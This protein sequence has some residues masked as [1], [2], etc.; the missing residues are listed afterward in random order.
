MKLH[1]PSVLRKALLLALAAVSAKVGIQ[2]AAASLVFDGVGIQTYADFGQNCGRYVAGEV[3][4]MLQAIRE[5]EK[6][7]VIRYVG[8]AWK[9][10][11]YTISLDQGMIDFSS[12]STNPV[13]TAVGYGFLATVAH[14]GVLSPTY[15]GLE[16]GDKNAIRYTSIDFRRGS[17]FHLESNTDYK[18]ARL[19]KLVTD[20]QPS[21][22]YSGENP[23]ELNGKYLYR[24]GS[25]AVDL[26]LVDANGNWSGTQSMDL[27]YSF[28]SGGIVTIEWADSPTHKGDHDG[29]F[30]IFHH[31]KNNIYTEI[32][33]KDFR[34]GELIATPNPLPYRVRSGDS[35]S[36]TW[37]YNEEARAYQYI[38]SG[39][40][41]GTYFSQD[42]GDL[43]WSEYTLTQFNVTADLGT[44]SHTI[45]IDPVTKKGEIIEGV[46]DGVLVSTT[47]YRGSMVYTNAAGATVTADF[48][49]VHLDTH[50]WKDL[51]PVKELSNWF[52]Y[53]SEYFNAAPYGSTETAPNKELCYADLF[54]T[55]SLV[56]EA[57]DSQQYDIQL[58]GNVDLGVGF[59]QFSK[60]ED[61]DSA[62][63]KLQSSYILDSAGF[64]IDKDVTLELDM[65][66]P[67]DH[68]TEWRK[69]GAGN[70]TITGTGDTNALLNVG[71]S[72][73]VSL[74]RTGG[75]AA[76]NVLVSSGSTLVVKDLKQVYRDVTLGAGGATLDLNGNDFT[77]NNSAA[78][79][80]VSFKSL[81]LLVEKDV[82]TNT[83]SQDITI[84]IIDPGTEAFVGA[85]K[86]TKDGGAIHVEYEGSTDREWVM[87]TVF[88]DLSHNSASD[89]TVKQGSVVLQGINTVHGR[90]MLGK[91]I[92]NYFDWH[93]ADAK[94]D[95]VVEDGAVF[96]LGSHA[97]LKGNVTVKNGGVFI[98]TEYTTHREEYMEGGVKMDDTYDYREYFGLHGDI[99]LV[100]GDS[101]FYVQFSPQHHYQDTDSENLYTNRI[102]GS[103]GMVVDT[104]G[105]SLRLTNTE[106][107]FRGVKILEGGTLA[108]TSKEALGDTSQYQW[109][110]Q[111]RGILI[112]ENAGISE[113]LPMVDATST[114]VLAL[115]TDVEDT[116]DLSGHQQ[117]IIGAVGKIQ[118]GKA[119]TET[120]LSANE[121]H[122]W[123]LGGGGGELYVNYKLNDADGVLVLGNQYTTG[124]VFLT[125]K[126]N[127]LRLITLVG[128]VTLDYTDPEALGHAQLSLKYGNRILGTKELVQQLTRDSDG[129]VLLDK[130]AKDAELD[131]RGHK[132]LSLSAEGRKVFSGTIALDAD[133]DTYNLGGGGGHLT[134]DTVLTDGP[135]NAKR[136]VLVDGQFFQAMYSEDGQDGGVIELTKALQ[137][138][139]DVT[140]QGFDANRVPVDNPLYVFNHFSTVTLQLSAEN[141][142]ESA[143]SILLKDGGFIDINGTS[144]TL[145]SLLCDVED[146]YWGLYGIVDNSEK[147][148]GGLVLN[149]TAARE[150]DSWNPILCNLL[151][152]RLTKTGDGMLYM[153]NVTETPL[154]SIED[155]TVV[156]LQN[157]ALD[158]RGVT[159][160]TGTGV[161][162][163]SELGEALKDKNIVLS[164][165][166][167]LR[168]GSDDV[169]CTVF[170]DNGQ[171]SIKQADGVSLSSLSGGIGA[172]RDA[173]L[174][175]NGMKFTLGG[176]MHNASGGTIDLQAGRLLLAEA[177]GVSIG[178]TLNVSQDATLASAGAADATYTIDRLNVGGR[179]LTIENNRQSAFWNIKALD[180]TGAVVMKS[181]ASESTL[182]LNGAGAFKGEL[183]VQGG[184]D[185]APGLI[186]AHDTAAQYASINLQGKAS[187]QLAT[188]NTQI[189]GLSG[190]AAAKVYT[191]VADATLTTTGEQAYTFAGSIVETEGG[192][193]NLVHGGS[194]HQ[195]YSGSLAVHNIAV[196]NGVLT[197]NAPSLDFTGNVIVARGG[198]LSTTNGNL[199]LHDGS[200]LC[201]E[202]AEG[203]A[204]V[205]TDLVVFNGGG[206]SFDVAG[207]A[208]SSS[209][210]LDFLGGV[211]VANGKTVS[212]KFTN[213]SALTIGTSLTLANGYNSA[214]DSLV[215]EGV[216]Y[217]KADFSVTDD[218]LSVAFSQADGYFIWDGTHE[219]H[220]WSSTRFG[221]QNRSPQASEVAVFNDSAVSKS[222]VLDG[223]T[224]V[225]SVLFDNSSDYTVVTE[226][227]S[228]ASENVEVRG[229]GTVTLGSLV[230][231]THQVSVAS[232]ATLVLSDANS[233]AFSASVDGGGKLAFDTHDTVTLDGKQVKISGI[234]V[235]SGTLASTQT[236]QT[237]GL[238][239]CADA[240]LS[241]NQ[242]TILSWGGTVHSSGT[243]RIGVSGNT[244]LTTNITAAE[245]GTA[246]MLVKTG[247]GTL[248]VKSAVAA[249]TVQVDA[250]RLV[251]EKAYLPQFLP[252][253]G[254]VVVNAGASAQIGQNAQ[255]TELTE[256]GANFVVNGGTLQ[257]ALA[258]KGIKTVSGDLSVTNGGTLHKWDGGLCFTGKA[259][260]G[261][262]AEDQVT[263]L[264]SWGKDGTIF[265]GLVE[266][267]GHVKLLRGNN[268]MEQFAFNNGAN[269]F[270]GGIE[271]TQGTKLVAGHQTA[272]A[273]ASSINLANNSTLALAADAV[274]IKSLN[275]SGSI[276]FIATE[277]RTAAILNITDGGDFS[278]SIEERI[279]INK[280]GAGTLSLTGTSTQFSGELHIQE[281]T[282]SLGSSAMDILNGATSVSVGRGATLQL[283]AYASV[284]G[285][286]E[287]QGTL[288]MGGTI[289]TRDSVNLGEDFSII[290]GGNYQTEGVDTRVYTVFS[291]GN[292]AALGEWETLDL[293]HFSGIGSAERG[294]SIEKL[295]VQDNNYQ[296]VVS[297]K[298][299]QN[300]AITWAE[301]V[302][303]GEWDISKSSNFT[304]DA[305]G[306]RTIY[307]TGDIVSIAS[308][309]DIT[310]ASAVNLDGSTLGVKAGADATIRQTAEHTLTM[311]TLEVQGGARL[312]INALTSQFASAANVAEDGLLEI[313]VSSIGNS[314]SVATLAGAGVVALSNTASL[315]FG[316]NALSGGNIDA[317]RFTGTLQLG[318]G[319]DTMRFRST[320]VV[321]L[322]SENTIEL[323]DK[324]QFWM[325]NR[326]TTIA[327][328]LILHGNSGQSA[329]ASWGSEGFGA[330]RGATA[331]NGS[332]AIDG[333]AMV[334]GAGSIAFNG[335][336][337][338]M[339]DND[340]LTFGGYHASISSQTYTLVA[341]MKT[342]N[343]ANMVVRQSGNNN[344]T[345]NVESTEGL[346][347]NLK[348]AAGVA[349]KG[350]VNVKADNEILHMES[351]AGDGV[352]NIEQSKFLGLA[353]GA[354]YG[355]LLNLAGAATLAA[356]ESTSTLKVIGGVKFSS[357]GENQVSITGDGSTMLENA[358]IHLAEGT[359]LEMA[360]IVLSADSLITDDAATIVAKGMKMAA[361]VGSNLQHAGTD[362]LLTGMQMLTYGAPTL[363]KTVES[364]E[365]DVVQFT[366]T[367]IQDVRIEG[368]GL[369]ISL[370]GDSYHSFADY[371]WASISL[372]QANGG[373]MFS[374]DLPVS[375]A[376]MAADGQVYTVAGMYNSEE[377]LQAQAVGMH[378]TVYFH[379]ADARVP[380]PASGALSLLALAAL[381]TRRRRK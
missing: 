273:K 370:V 52:N 116:V 343:L 312:R 250:G 164:G 81:H 338:G 128:G 143:E 100:D 331:F 17:P 9:N 101:M 234:E 139:G 341:G 171:A 218:V 168:V 145:N 151:V 224:Q 281:G 190:D 150:S 320:R 308:K 137:L 230:S 361:N 298:N 307:M 221:Q 216:D 368:T 200:V 114:G 316:N 104:A 280:T 305:G 99:H 113:I 228:L 275:G 25:G 107:D 175:L 124:K 10:E 238:T 227:G 123:H 259:T 210:A 198:K 47:P 266:G 76:Y 257:L 335:D 333:N 152:P 263:L 174:E 125:N 73:T 302:E 379:M 251:V 324:A 144:Q 117:L 82:V 30:G 311:E 156:I 91:R 271:T 226:A 147:Q 237:S 247:G 291:G 36:P 304:E 37:V 48:I 172:A 94:M 337:K 188:G 2:S 70:L 40:S 158:S 355:G 102:C 204:G 93:Y 325:D 364:N 290:L 193:M 356:Q 21:E 203:A 68:M 241:T 201:S 258:Q 292:R 34:T 358:H 261:A 131:L 208:S 13:D 42:R 240:C 246:G 274:D 334:S 163:V 98:M 112:V 23:S 26:A 262:S 149:V 359:R 67:K 20:V 293:S 194:G 127:N 196:Q 297:T 89:F 165:G 285:P 215:A 220:S 64:A 130:I 232:G 363:A 43:E 321:G 306:A 53:G 346:A 75:Y 138:T 59:V 278:G 219:K 92:V 279:S 380:E 327:A 122:E 339:G 255:T 148:T 105:G 235:R 140:V 83:S 362:S 352:V 54:M 303:A 115:V 177:G 136:N 29:N 166:G 353:G 169:A 55:N 27:P 14:N 106:N 132:D 381:A 57:G 369:V 39:Q 71:G 189:A 211:N 296:V 354:D 133:D 69:A 45:T 129:V 187:M 225:A 170:V 197:V 299:M 12:A 284:I 109:E 135:G 88:T 270:S 79:D 86:D 199:T 317:T 318:N 142:L 213:A 111:D 365:R 294:V 60:A 146:I 192:R 51:N 178:G 167:S 159:R 309:A 340:T 183:Q 141:A 62:S 212:V 121:A 90:Q 344:T 8:G 56:F 207:Q 185:T 154:F 118:F 77:W 161:L 256:I 260:L 319:K 41:G 243:V 328:N 217:L 162:D 301:E 61:V 11:T 7:I 348:F 253:V 173:T 277:N 313:S 87:N 134:L 120:E 18:M 50:T 350:V 282:V 222:V 22:F 35:G 326:N 119:N 66:N 345:V 373:A 97:R 49:G 378:A 3:N 300:M 329:S 336:I 96:T 248:Y 103:G 155:G 179:T 264:G 376:Y 19:N 249:D 4:D 283:A 72:G 377:S 276:G 244:D 272:L 46:G 126:Q 372:D 63:F 184:T 310:M 265:N 357:T 84:T 110:I 108:A 323:N 360:N 38:S 182:L 288:A 16:V 231:I 186:L 314:A 252:T 153:E 286:M 202:G 5:N 209:A 223:D 229:S 254:T 74:Q 268:N 85:F 349:G 233:L 239:V 31:F 289:S 322:D 245:D 374:E 295:R 214:P 367:N 160:V 267:Q 236:L 58:T 78:P 206:M 15:S 80:G 287:I 95:V 347:D 32:T 269:T 6:G 181:G 33:G 1:L 157:Q 176:S 191:G 375:L 242:G 371:A 65:V 366:L 330:V 342:E 332:V 315:D 44:T 205:L 195:V 28:A 24:T 180:G 351:A